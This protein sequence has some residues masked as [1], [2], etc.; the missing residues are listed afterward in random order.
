MHT[1]TLR[2]QYHGLTLGRQTA[3]MGIVN[4]TPDSFS[5]GGRFQAVDAAVAHA[6]HLVRWGA[7]IIDIGGESTR[8]FAAAVSPRDEIARVLPVIERLADRVSAPISIDTTK[9]EVAEAALDAGASII[10][11]ISALRMDPQMAATAA[12]HGVPVIL[13]HM[14]GTPRTMQVE[15]TYNDV[16][17][18]VRAFLDDAIRRAVAAGISRKMI[19]VDPG[20][21]FGKTGRHN[22]ILIRHLED[23]VDLGVPILVGPSRKRFIR[24]LVKGPGDKDPA[25]DQQEVETG[26]QAAVAAS[27]MHGA[28]IVRVHDVARTRA[29]LRV[30]DAIRGV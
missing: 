27:V 6:E 12:R 16:V 9:A 4:V 28:H 14:Q 11:D 21:G 17:A 22:L 1:H 3:I 5:D 26:T 10:N 30:L 20:I 29:T 7:D 18:E 15:P 8:P 24:D 2:W 23:L 19:I 13:M 25:P